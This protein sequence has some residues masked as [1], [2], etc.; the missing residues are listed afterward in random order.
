MSD[1]DRSTGLSGSTTADTVHP[2]AELTSSVTGEM[3]RAVLGMNLLVSALA[4]V[5]ALVI[6]G[7]LIALSSPSVIEAAG[8]FFARPQDTIAAIWQSITSAYSALFQGALVNLDALRE[9]NISR[10]FYPLSEKLTVSAPLILAGL[11]AEG[12]T[13]VN[14]VYHLDRGYERVEAKLAAVGADIERLPG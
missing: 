14:R 9:G 10:A 1:P 7:V 11:A 6:G 13:I 8:Y 3:R 4:V 12:E 5:L 2:P